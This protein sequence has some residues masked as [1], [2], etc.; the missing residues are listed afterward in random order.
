MLKNDIWSEYLVKNVKSK[1]TDLTFFQY[2]YKESPSI[3]INFKSRYIL[4]NVYSTRSVNSEMNY[5][6]KQVES[7]DQI[8][9]IKFLVY[10]RHVKA[11]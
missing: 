10:F 11:K 1:K 8:A 6:P 9:L 3:S 2:I 4:R 5:V 7:K